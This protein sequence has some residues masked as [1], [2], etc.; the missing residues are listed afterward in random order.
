MDYPT[1]CLSEYPSDYP[2]R[3]FL[4]NWFKRRGYP[5]AFGKFIPYEEAIKKD[6]DLVDNSLESIYQGEPGEFWHMYFLVEPVPIFA[7]PVPISP[8]NPF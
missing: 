6:P 2:S 7:E 1:D 4:V 5:V 8:N 3:E